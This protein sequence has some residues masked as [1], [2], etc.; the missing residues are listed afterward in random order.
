MYFLLLFDSISQGKETEQF[1]NDEI[2]A[3]LQQSEPL[4]VKLHNYKLNGQKFQC[5]FALHPV[6]GPAPETEYKFQIGV[7]L[8]Y[9]DQD[10]DLPRKLIE[11]GRILRNLPQ[12]VGGDKLPGVDTFMAD[13][14]N[15]HG[16]PKAAGMI[17]D[18]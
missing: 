5:L 14:E 13:L 12:S 6:F 10:P 15:T 18:P 11:M 16:P 2:M 1:L 7:Q 3:A 9:N 17:D 4:L 8:D